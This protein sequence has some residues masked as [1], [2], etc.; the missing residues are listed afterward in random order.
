MCV[1]MCV[2]WPQVEALQKESNVR[3]NYWREQT[4][5]EEEM[6]GDFDRAIKHYLSTS[7]HESDCVS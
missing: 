5:K 7:I 2:C 6:V 3:G 4:L 1:Q